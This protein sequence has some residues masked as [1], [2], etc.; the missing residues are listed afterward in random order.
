MFLSRTGRVRWGPTKPT[1][2]RRFQE[3]RIRRGEIRPPLA[4]YQGGTRPEPGY[5]HMLREQQILYTRGPAFTSKTMRIV[6]RPGIAG[7]Y[8]ALR[9]ADTIHIIG[10]SLPTAD[11]GVR[12]LF[13]PIRERLEKGNVGRTHRPVRSGS[14]SM[15]GAPWRRPGV[16]STAA[17]RAVARRLWRTL[18]PQSAS[19]NGSASVVRGVRPTQYA[20]YDARAA[21]G[22]TVGL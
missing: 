14:G 1:Q 9:D 13:N 10:S 7:G 21:V 2:S 8:S 15:G 22:Q 6:N 20:D 3:R 12:L 19:I 16:A 5:A 18:A 17:R 11:L 4:N